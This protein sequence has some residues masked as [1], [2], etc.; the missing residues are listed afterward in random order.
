[1]SW[2]S[3]RG[4][5]ESVKVTNDVVELVTDK[6][7]WKFT[8]EG[9]CCAHAFIHQPTTAL[10]DLSYLIGTKIV[11]GYVTDGVD[12]NHDGYVRTIHFYNLQTEKGTATVTLYIDH[13][14]DYGGRLLGGKQ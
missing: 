9:D 8:P 2:E 5:L 13:N 14:G 4:T 6:G 3:I 11:Q 7:T 12:R 1:M 10:A